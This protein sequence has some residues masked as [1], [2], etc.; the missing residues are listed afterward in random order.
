MCPR[1][2]RIPQCLARQISA[3]FDARQRRNER[4]RAG[5]NDEGLGGHPAFAI[6]FNRPRVNKAGIALHTVDAEVS[7]PLDAVM[8]FD[9]GNDIAHAAHHCGEI[10]DRRASAYAKA[11]RVSN[12]V[13][14]LG[15]FDQRL[16]RNASGVQAITAHFVRFD[17]RHL[18]LDHRRD[19]G[20]D[21]TRRTSADDD[22][23]TVKPFGL[24]PAFSHG[25]ASP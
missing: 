21:Q 24:L 14:D 11:R 22:E 3:V 2:H 20:R 4:G 13:R 19:I 15:A 23:V 16:G 5:S 9:G 1:R 10:H 25:C 12:L 8:W 6:D 18:G 7:K 17:Q